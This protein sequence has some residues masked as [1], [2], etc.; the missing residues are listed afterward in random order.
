MQSEGRLPPGT[1]R[2]YPSALAAYGIIAKQ[3]REQLLP[4]LL[5]ATLLHTLALILCLHER[6]QCRAWF[7]KSFSAFALQEGLAGL[8]TGLGPNVMRNAIINAAELASYDQVKEGLLS[9]GLFKD[10][11]YCHLAAGLGAGFIAVCVGSPVRGAARRGW[12]L[13]LSLESL[14]FDFVVCCPP[15]LC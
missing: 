3:A 13:G 11:I 15:T 4:A 7:Q 12:K 6:K 14:G 5:R 2:R 10:N 9:T 8:W 1:P